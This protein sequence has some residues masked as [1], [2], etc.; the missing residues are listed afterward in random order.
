MGDEFLSEKV[1]M[2]F[3]WID[4]SDAKEQHFCKSFGRC[5]LH[6]VSARVPRTL[7]QTGARRKIP[8]LHAGPH[9]QRRVPALL[10]LG[11]SPT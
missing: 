11:R 6:L 9:S 5:A 1:K 4:L 10:V 8:P 3:A 2:V 7:P